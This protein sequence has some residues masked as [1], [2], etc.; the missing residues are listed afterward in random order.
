MRQYNPSIERSLLCEMSSMAS[1][2]HCHFRVL[3]CV[4]AQK[5]SDILGFVNAWVDLMIVIKL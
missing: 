2:F 4:Q 5:I 1:K 3:F